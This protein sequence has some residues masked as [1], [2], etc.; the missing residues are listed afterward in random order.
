MDIKL[1]QIQVQYQT[2]EFGQ[3]YH[4]NEITMPKCPLIKVVLDP[5]LLQR[6]T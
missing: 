2:V 4:L 6:G 5:R 3:I 1:N